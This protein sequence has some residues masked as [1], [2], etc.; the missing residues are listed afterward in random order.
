M[1]VLRIRS[2][3]VGWMIN[4]HLHV[5]LSQILEKFRKSSLSQKDFLNFSYLSVEAV[6]EKV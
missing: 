4:G 6:V 3:I 5:P 1:P 2:L